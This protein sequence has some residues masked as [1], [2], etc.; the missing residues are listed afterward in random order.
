MFFFPPSP[1]PECVSVSAAHLISCVFALRTLLSS[2]HGRPCR[3]KGGCHHFRP[4]TFH[5]AVCSTCS[6]RSTCC[7]CNFPRLLTV[8]LTIDFYFFFPSVIGTSANKLSRKTAEQH[9]ALNGILCHFD[10]DRDFIRSLL[11]SPIIKCQ[12]LRYH[13]R[14]FQDWILS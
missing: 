4:C 11:H 10:Y 9:F 6:A 12:Y 14:H 8:G 13:I 3:V 1:H 7:N 5:P 2:L